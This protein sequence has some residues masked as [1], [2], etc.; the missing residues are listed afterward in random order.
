MEAEEEEATGA[1]EIATNLP[2]P[3]INKCLS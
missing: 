2:L 1:E 3:L